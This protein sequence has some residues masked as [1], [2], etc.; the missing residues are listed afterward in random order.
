MQ[1][2]EISPKWPTLFELAA[3]IPQVD[4]APGKKARGGKNRPPVTQGIV[5]EP[6]PT[7]EG[8]FEVTPEQLASLVVPKIEV[9]SDI[10]GFQREKTNTHARKIARAM[11]AG[12]EMPPIEL[13]IFVDD[14]GKA[15]AAEVFVGDG[16]HRG[17]GAIIARKPLEVIV[18]RRTIEQARRLFTN[19]SKAKNLRSDDTLLTGNSPLELYIQDAV[20]SDDHPWS[21]LVAPYK[22]ERR[23][24]PTTMAIIVG[25]FVYNTLNQGVTFH[26]TRPGDDFDHNQA[27]RLATLIRSFG[28]KTTNGLAFRGRSLRAISFAAVYVFR[29]NPSLKDGDVERW[30]QHMPKFDFSKYPHL[31]GKEAEMA[32]A[33]VEHWNKRLPEERKVK[34]WTYR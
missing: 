8:L 3:Q 11:L 12:D 32:V 34:P 4:L 6:F 33:L 19:Q 25:S 21:D 23:M 18:K 30:K 20:T 13:S 15:L 14:Q 9:E 26:T 2:L 29:R 24:T 27:D 7:K 17:L 28:S 5:P 1:T 31:L 10:R 16:Q 22:S